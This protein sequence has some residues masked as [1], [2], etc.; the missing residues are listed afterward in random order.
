MKDNYIYPALFTKDT[1]GISV[2]FPDLPGCLTCGS[3]VE[4]AMWM[5]KDALPLHI[6]G[7]EEDGDPIPK[8]SDFE[9]IKPGENQYLAVIEARMIPYR[10]RMANK[11]VKK[12][13]TIPKWLDDLANEHH[14]N[15]SYVLQDALKQKLGAG[16]SSKKTSRLRRE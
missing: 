1:D 5:A 11:A 15:F 10:D 12:T 2:E 4:E 13:L 8:P 7:L 14:V 6:Y 16:E 3:T 9:S